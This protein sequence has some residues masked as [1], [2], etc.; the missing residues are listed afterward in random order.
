MKAHHLP[1]RDTG[2]VSMLICDYLDGAQG[3]KAFH[4]GAPSFKNLHRQ[5]LQKKATYPLDI[6]SSL[7]TVLTEQYHG[8]DTSPKVVE[9]IKLLQNKTTLTVTT[10]HQLSLMTGPLYFIYKIISTIKL[11]QQLK[12]KFSDLD[13]V[14]VYWMASE[15]HDFEEIRSFI[16]KGKKFQWN[17]NAA[18]AVGKIKTESLTPLLDLFKKELGDSIDGVELRNLIERSYESENNLSVATRIFVNHLFG[19]YGLLILD[20]DHCKL[21]HYFTP[22]IKEDLLNHT[23][24]QEVL[25]QI[26]SIKK[27]YSKTFKPQVNPR[28]VN[29]FLLQD[30]QRRRIMKIDNG[31]RL[32]GSNQIFSSE[33]M[34][35]EIDQNPE[36][37]SP[38]VLLRPLYQELILPNIAYFGGGGELAYWLELKSLFD[39]QKLLFP[40]LCLR[41]M[42]LIIPEKS[43][44]KIR[45]L[46]LDV[47]DLFLKRNAL[48]NKKVRQ[49]SNI[50][51]DLSPLKKEMEIQFDHLE[52]LISETDASFEGAVRAQKSKQFKGI[53]HLEKR[54]LK[55]QKKKL[56]DHIERLVLVHEELFPG[57]NLQERVENFSAF[58]IEKGNDFKSFLMEAFDPLSKEFTF[59]E[60]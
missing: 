35:D 25:N 15:D 51:L 27:N 26:A 8:V 13:F 37:F 44:K 23:C 9:H 19:H 52:A 28:E 17:T 50:D 32:E 7:C 21:K 12:K 43:A 47:S 33:Q 40:I 2:Y 14:P 58:H 11:S 24:N 42:A 31:Y 41:N 6:R 22:I 29:L 57:G 38:N 48:I 4:N 55:A 36:K 56:K 3:L 18:G 16:F 10:G 1:L 39:S 59:I 20:A 45:N 34:M 46:K 54:L 49:I 53:D 60:I 5:A 30:G